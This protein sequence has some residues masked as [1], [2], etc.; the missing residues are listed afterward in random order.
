M[1]CRLS[2]GHREVSGDGR[3]LSVP[4]G[5]PGE[6]VFIVP[7]NEIRLGR[8]PEA[9]P[10]V[11]VATTGGKAR[12]GN[13]FEVRS[14]PAC[15]HCDRQGI[16][17]NKLK[18][19]NN[20]NCM[21]LWSHY[22]I[23]SRSALVAFESAARHGNFSRAAGE[24]RTSQAAISRRIA[25]LE[26]TLSTRLFERS[27]SGVT[28][29][30]AGRR[31]RNGVVAGLHV[32][33]AAADEAAELSSGNR[34]VIAC[35]H[36]ASHLVI[37]PRYDALL[38]A[39]GED[40]RIRLLVH[41]RRSEDLTIDPSA[42]LVLTWNAASAVPGA[43]PEDIAPVF[44]EEVQPICSPGYAETH[45][46]VL[47][48]PASGWS[49]LTLLDMNLPDPAWA[50]WSDWFAAAGGS[51]PKCRC[52]RFD[53]YLDV[54]EAAATGKGIA[55]GWRHCIEAYLDSGALV[56]LDDGFVEFGGSFVAVLTAKGRRNPDARACLS[57]FERRSRQ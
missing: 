43:A 55:V 17:A 36:D 4:V 1:R 26:A 48:G 37:L 6:R 53:T 23:P 44:A 13:P 27:R 46:D 39:L 52:E 51:A 18:I 35:S 22:R 40:V 33:R 9:R 56:T 16:G 54:L 11:F 19:F 30:E 8:P 3:G 2:G 34:V 5:P 45:A 21:S 49:G 50:S 24:L 15:R 31:F 57:F 7:W 41:K 28:L 25:S 42:D 32:L 29:T 10:G 20:E 47:A 14:L 38:D 12:S